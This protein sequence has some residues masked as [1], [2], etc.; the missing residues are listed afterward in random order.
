MKISHKMYCFQFGNHIAKAHTDIRPSEAHPLCM[1]A[2]CYDPDLI[3]KGNKVFTVMRLPPHC[4]PVSNL[5]PIAIS[6]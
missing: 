6:L 3:G 5:W 2:M 1:Y 4:P